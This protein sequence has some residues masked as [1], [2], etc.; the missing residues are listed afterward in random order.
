MHRGIQHPKYAHLE[1]NP[2]YLGGRIPKR[3]GRYGPP[4]IVLDCKHSMRPMKEEV[5]EPIFSLLPYDDLQ[6]ANTNLGI[7]HRTI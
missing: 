2:V 4:T 6:E 1:L 5:I 7:N 3:K